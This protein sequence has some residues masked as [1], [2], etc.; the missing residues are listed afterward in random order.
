[1]L[2]DKLVTCFWL[3]CLLSP[4]CWNNL[5]FPQNC[6]IWLQL[7][8][9]QYLNEEIHFFMGICFSSHLYGFRPPT[10]C[11]TSQ[12]AQKTKAIIPSTSSWPPIL[13]LPH[14]ISGFM[15]L[16]QMIIL[17]SNKQ[18]CCRQDLKTLH[19]QPLSHP[20]HHL[21]SHYYVPAFRH[22]P[23]PRDSNSYTQMQLQ[24]SIWVLHNSRSHQAYNT[25]TRAS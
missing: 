17:T 22:A 20:R 1:M 11:F 16:I 4:T 5:F 14:F 23:P 19:H 12:W 3:K 18:A 10:S 6:N 9:Q 24:S 25:H 2:C 8:S 13:K 7:I 21:H 15:Q